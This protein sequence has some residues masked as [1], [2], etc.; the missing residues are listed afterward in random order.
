MSERPRDP[1]DVFGERLG[2]VLG[3]PERFGDD[4]ERSLVAAIRADRPIRLRLVPRARRF[5]PAW[6]KTPASVRLSPIAATALAAGLAAL[7]VFSTRQIDRRNTRA[8]RS[9]ASTAAVH[10]TV[11]FVRFVFVGQAKSVSL[12]GDFNRWGTEPTPLVSAN[13]VWTASIPLQN[14]RHEYAFIVDGAR[15]VPD[16]LAPSSSDE[17]DTKSSIVTVGT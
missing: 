11:T 9:I 8:P 17:F 14:G 10:D 12:V 6:W 16:P 4:F 5:S 15:W 2:R 1:D 13:G 7:A 3:Q